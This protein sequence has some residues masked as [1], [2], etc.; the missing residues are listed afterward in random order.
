MLGI[1]ELRVFLNLALK[2]VLHLHDEHCLAFGMN[3]RF[4]GTLR[5]GILDL[6]GYF[7]VEFQIWRDVS[8]W[9]FDNYHWGCVPANFCC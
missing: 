6:E 8:W 4:G 2:N 3:F 1:N 9:N 5:G 7:M